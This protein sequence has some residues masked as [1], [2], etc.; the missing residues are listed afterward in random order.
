MPASGLVDLVGD[1]GRQL[2]HRRDAIDVSQLRLRF[3]GI[4]LLPLS[5]RFS[6]ARLRSVKSS[7]KATPWSWPSPEGRPAEKN[8]HAAAVLA[9]V[10]FLENHSRFPSS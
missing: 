7:T 10:L 2:P 4:R 3:A 5:R 1:R 6:S 9:Q 8:R